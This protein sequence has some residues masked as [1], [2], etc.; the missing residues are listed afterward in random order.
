MQTVLKCEKGKTTTTGNWQTVC[1][2]VAEKITQ[3]QD[4]KTEL[5]KQDS[6]K[7]VKRLG[8]FS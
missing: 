4:A 2:N 3:K 5:K 7:W 8:R 6:N 1:S